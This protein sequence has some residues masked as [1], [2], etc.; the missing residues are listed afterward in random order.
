[1]TLPASSSRALA[2]NSAWVQLEQQLHRPQGCLTRLL[3]ADIKGDGVIN[4]FSNNAR[5][6]VQIGSGQPYLL[7][8]YPARQPNFFTWDMRLSKDFKFGER[9]QLR[10]VA[11]IFNVTNRG[12]LYSN[13]DNSGFVDV[14]G[15]TPIAGSIS[16]SCPPI[17]AIPRQGQAIGP[18][19]STYGVLDQI[20]PGSSFAAQLGA[21]FSRE[22]SCVIQAAS[23]V[24]G[25]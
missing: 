25:L 17:T 6:A 1:L 3:S 9:Y 24:G 15:C 7:P 23:R 5:P 2:L 12:N 10:L 20:S 4:Q 16:S 8:R 11:D 21:R 19:G 14:P 13:P 22:E 18:N